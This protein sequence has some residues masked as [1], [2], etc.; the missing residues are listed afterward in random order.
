MV[1]SEGYDSKFILIRR[2]TTIFRSNEPYSS[3]S[4]HTDG[5]GLR[6]IR[7]ENYVE[8]HNE[9]GRLLGNVLFKKFHFVE[10][11]PKAG[12]RGTLGSKVRLK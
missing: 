4:V 5:S 8:M 1:D 11:R 3:A 6:A 12:T 10:D 2:R 7:G 9:V